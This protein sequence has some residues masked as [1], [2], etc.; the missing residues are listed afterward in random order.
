[1]DST[2]DNGAGEPRSNSY[3]GAGFLLRSA[4]EEQG[5]SLA[6]MATRTRI[7]LR[8]LEV[9][10][11][12]AF[13]TLPSRTYAVGF[14]RTYARSIG[15]D[16][17]TILQA[18]RSELGDSS[19]PRTPVSSAMEPGDPAKLPSRGLAW[20]AAAGALLLA[21]GL[22]AWFGSRYGAGEG[23]GPL[24]A[25]ATEADAGETVP[26]AADAA[27]PA[28]DARVVTF[29]ALED[30]VWV[31]LYQEGGER[32][33]EKTLVRGES[34]TIPATVSD[35][36][37]STGRPDALGITIDGQPVAK[38]AERPMN[39]GGEPVTAAALL[40]RPGSAAAPTPVPG[41]DTA[42]GTAGAATRRPAATPRARSADPVVTTLPEAP[43]PAPE[44]AAPAPTTERET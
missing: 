14:A 34:F 8:Q 42:T 41:L 1:M 24:T 26:A 25:D 27:A 35:P 15:L 12:G 32:L 38:L 44:P 19:E 7:P 5:L 23:P 30:D 33:L 28:Q 39:I 21:L 31:R 11:A 3:T 18:V 40:A 2:Q 10:E 43:A 4:R 37:L 6:D 17:K 29:T 20:A 22:F 13:D 36:R 9:I 16:E